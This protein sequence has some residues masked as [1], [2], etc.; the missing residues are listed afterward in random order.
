[1]LYRVSNSLTPPGD[2]AVL[3]SPI[4][5]YTDDQLTAV[6]S[7]ITYSAK[8]FLYQLQPILEGYKGGTPTQV[9]Y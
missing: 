4:I 5:A 7:Y 9:L 8:D 3:L 6:L 2:Q 1:M